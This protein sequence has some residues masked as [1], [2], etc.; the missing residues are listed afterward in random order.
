MGVGLEDRA[1]LGKCF[2]IGVTVQEE[3]LKI[4]L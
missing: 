1:E 2:C 4:R 3:A